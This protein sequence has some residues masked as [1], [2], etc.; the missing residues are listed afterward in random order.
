MLEQRELHG[1]L[2]RVEI[3][4]WDPQG[5]EN[6]RPPALLGAPHCA[7]AL[8]TEVARNVLKLLVIREQLSL[9]LLVEAA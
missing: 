2:I 8:P 7:P 9:G 4:L 5:A 3:E 6:V 1:G